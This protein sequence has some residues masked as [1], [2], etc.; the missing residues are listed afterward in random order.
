MAWVHVALQ[1]EGE[2]GQARLVVNGAVDT[3]ISYGYH[4]G[5]GDRLSIAADPPHFNGFVDDLV[6]VDR[7]LS[8]DEI[9]AYLESEAPPS[10]PAVPRA[11]A[12]YWPLVTSPVTLDVTSWTEI[13]NQASRVALSRAWLPWP[14]Q[15]E[16]VWRQESGFGRAYLRLM[17]KRG[18]SPLQVLQMDTLSTT[19]DLYRSALFSLPHTDSV[20]SED[21][22]YLEVRNTN[23]GAKVHIVKAGLV[24]IPGGGKTSF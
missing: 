21:E 6:V 14:V 9:Q 17:Q 11:Q 5:W 24:M 20:Y 16:V 1:T 2:S 13:S 19:V 18:S 12:L 10:A 4:F 23:S 15:L 7:Y 3:E 8:L 22:Y